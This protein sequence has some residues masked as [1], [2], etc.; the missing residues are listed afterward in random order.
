M[1]T[2]NLHKLPLLAGRFEH[3]VLKLQINYG[4]LG[5]PHC[6]T[7]E[8]SIGYAESDMRMVVYKVRGRERLIAHLCAL[9]VGA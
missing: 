4:L 2:A 8:N 5:S 6:E 1:S 9:V 3:S 7:L